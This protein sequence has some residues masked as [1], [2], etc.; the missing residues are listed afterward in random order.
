[1][2]QPQYCGKGDPKLVINCSSEHLRIDTDKIGKNVAQQHIL[3][4]CL[5]IMY[6]VNWNRRRVPVCK[7]CAGSCHWCSG[8][9]AEVPTAGPGLPVATL[10][11]H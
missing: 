7:G 9:T 4:L 11:P 3:L 5:H 2:L 1:M 6:L 10:T 8:L